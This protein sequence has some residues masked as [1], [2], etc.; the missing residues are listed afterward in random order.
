[1]WSVAASQQDAF[2]FTYQVETHVHKW[3][4]ELWTTYLHL[5]IQENETFWFEMDA[6]LS[7]GGNMC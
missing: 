7:V 3:V 6:P 4:H 5:L 2:Q 1:M